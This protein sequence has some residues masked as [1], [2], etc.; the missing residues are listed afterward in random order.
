MPAAATAAVQLNAN[1]NSPQSQTDR[2]TCDL[3]VKE[4]GVGLHSLAGEHADGCQHAHAAVSQLR[5]PIPLHLH[6]PP[7][8]KS[9][10][11]RVMSEVICTRSCYLA[12][13]FN[14]SQDILGKSFFGATEGSVCAAA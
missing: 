12:L 6:T 2:S 13:K 9:C 3:R 10:M 8:L 5:L 1:S 4:G 7:P 11:S 14:C